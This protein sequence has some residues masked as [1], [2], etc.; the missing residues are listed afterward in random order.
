MGASQV[1]REKRLRDLDDTVHRNPVALLDGERV[2][3]RLQL[4]QWNPLCKR[5]MEPR[6]QGRARPRAGWMSA[7]DILA[8]NAG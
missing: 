5:Q 3:G 6:L 1:S 4:D 7:W 8:G 2:V